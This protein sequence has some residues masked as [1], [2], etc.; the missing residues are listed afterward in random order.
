MLSTTEYND[1]QC[2][3]CVICK[4]LYA[5]LDFCIYALNL[6]CIHEVDNFVDILFLT[7]R[8]GA[9]W[10]KQK[11]YFKFTNPFYRT[12]S[13]CFTSPES[14]EKVLSATD[15]ELTF[16]SQVLRV[17]IDYSMPYSPPQ[18]DNK[19]AGWVIAVKNWNVMSRTTLTLAECFLF[20][21]DQ[22]EQSFIPHSLL[23]ASTGMSLCAS[24]L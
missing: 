3:F 8:Y 20:C 15:E 21:C 1:R 17:K 22:L 16:Y 14:V 6:L 13:V 23:W 10:R 9:I 5:A 4:A 19:V 18:A 11:G 12:G 2:K 7:C 24:N